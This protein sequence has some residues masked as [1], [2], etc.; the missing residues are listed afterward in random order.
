MILLKIS[1]WNADIDA[2]IDFVK[3]A[4]LPQTAKKWAQHLMQPF[5]AIVAF[6][7][8]QVKQSLSH[9]ERSPLDVVEALGT[10][11]RRHITL[12]WSVASIRATIVTISNSTITSTAATGFTRCAI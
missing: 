11:F 12:L 6:G 3:S 1:T 10:C 2:K 7:M 8:F 4:M 9:P 5:I